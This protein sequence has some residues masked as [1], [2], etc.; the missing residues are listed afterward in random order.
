MT[1]YEIMMGNI[2]KIPVRIERKRDIRK[3]KVNSYKCGFD[4]KYKGRDEY[5]GI[6]V[7]DSLYI[8]NDGMITHNSGKSLIIA[9]IIENISLMF[10]NKS[11][12]LVPTLQLVDQFKGDLIEYT[13]AED[14]IGK[15]NSK[16]KEFDKE[17]VI[18][19]W[20]SMQNQLDKLDMFDTVIIDECVSGDTL[21]LT[22]N[23]VVKIK[24]IDIG[25]IV[26]SYNIST[27]EYENDLVEN[28]FVNNPL[29]SND[30]M[31]ELLM[32]NG[33]ILQIT[34]NHKVLTDMGYKKV[35]DLKKYD[36]IL[37]YP[38]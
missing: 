36:D 14:R 19:T 20:Q 37:S 16:Y 22:H 5:Y 18:S 4:V 9:Y 38:I 1:Q 2:D 11:L 10:Q 17:I 25:D 26:I 12:I 35:K 23:G 7:D 30:D 32:E 3:K 13:M 8:T 27:K 31:Y 6:E 24:D 29:T 28:V 21:I 33:D 34:G 15:V